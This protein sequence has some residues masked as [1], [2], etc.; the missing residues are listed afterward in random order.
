[1]LESLSG[2]LAVKGHG[3]RGPQEMAPT[4]LCTGVNREADENQRGESVQW[5]KDVRAAV[6]RQ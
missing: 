3:R 1:M 4:G 6:G 2:D 5:R